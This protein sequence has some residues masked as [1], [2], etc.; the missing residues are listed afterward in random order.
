MKNSPLFNNFSDEEY[1]AVMEKPLFSSAQ[2]PSGSILAEE[3]DIV[4]KFWFVEDGLVHAFRSNYDGSLDLFY[5]Y[6]KNDYPAL[7]LVFTRTK[8]SILSLTAAVDS[9]LTV[10]DEKIF[11]EGVYDSEIREKFLTNALRLL[12]N[13]SIRK[14]IKIDV[15]YKKSLRARICVF[16]NH[17]RERAGSDTFEINMNREQMAQF[18]G[19]NRSSLSNEIGK[20]RDEKII[21]CRKG[22]F[23][24][25]DP[26]LG[27]SI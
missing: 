7:D 5:L 22:S 21:E 15:L 17:M 9:K 19:V 3:G 8:K 12:A 23:K 2:Y 4:E 25:L 18:L 1:K 27:N 14:Q 26:S 13:E 24:I 6:S 16:F 11:R 10:I 20:M